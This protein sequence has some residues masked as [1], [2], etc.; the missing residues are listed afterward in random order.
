MIRKQLPLKS[1]KKDEG[2]S[3]EFLVEQLQAV[4]GRIDTKLDG[5]KKHLELKIDFSRQDAKGHLESVAG[6]IHQRID[7][8]DKR[9][10]SL[11]NRTES[12]EGAVLETNRE[13]KKISGQ[14]GPLTEKVELHNREIAAL[15]ENLL[16][17]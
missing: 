17:S 2:L 15:K 5:L 7:G 4:E 12:V 6:A 3:K 13:V 14:M 10:G 11:E 16:L 9:M 1:Q 8:L